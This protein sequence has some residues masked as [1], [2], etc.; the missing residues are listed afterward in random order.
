MNVSKTFQ[1]SRHRSTAL[2]LRRSLATALSSEDRAAAMS[3]LS[4]GG[5]PFPWEEVS[6]GVTLSCI[7]VTRV[8]LG[9]ISHNLMLCDFSVSSLCNVPGTRTERHQKD[10]HL[11]RL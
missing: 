6:V 9:G 8:F 1:I 5:S 11:S 2:V 3:K 7:K 4:G 10:V